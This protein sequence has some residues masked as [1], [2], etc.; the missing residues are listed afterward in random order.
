MKYVQY[1]KC[2]PIN[3]DKLYFGIYTL[4]IYVSAHQKQE[5]FIACSCPSKRG[6]SETSDKFKAIDEHFKME[7]IH[8]L[9]D[10]LKKTSIWSEKI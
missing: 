4:V 5:G 1:V 10:L 8:M 9:R 3:I 7:N 6:W 2:E